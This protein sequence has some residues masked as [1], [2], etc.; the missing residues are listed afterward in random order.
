MVDVVAVG[1]VVVIDELSGCGT[2]D[3]DP[4]AATAA[5]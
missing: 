2:P 1:R 4:E 3:L 5:P